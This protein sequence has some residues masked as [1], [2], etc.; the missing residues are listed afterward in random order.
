[1]CCPMS[2]SSDVIGMMTFDWLHIYC[3]TDLY[4]SIRNP[5]F[6]VTL[7]SFLVNKHV[8]I[9]C[10]QLIIC[11]FEASANQSTEVWIALSARISMS[12]CGCMKYN[13]T[14][15]F[16]TKKKAQIVVTILF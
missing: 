12:S 3:S 13:Y 6:K 1:M 14:R 10:V 8:Y 2:F 11:I 9:Q 7:W 5:L 15:I 4:G 16:K